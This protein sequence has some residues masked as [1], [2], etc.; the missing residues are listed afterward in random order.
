MP[1]Y[2]QCE[3]W[4]Q[5]C[6]GCQCNDLERSLRS[7]QQQSSGSGEQQCTGSYGNTNRHKYADPDTD[8]DANADRDPNRNSHAHG[9]ANRHLYVYAP[10][11]GYF[12]ADCCHADGYFNADCCY[13]NGY[14]QIDLYTV[15]D[16]N[17]CTTAFFYGYDGS[18]K[19]NA[20]G[21]P[22][23]NSPQWADVHAVADLY[24]LTYLRG[25][26]D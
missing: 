23:T 22:Y 25:N 5:W 2:S 20:I 4:R 13:A 14:K 7:G 17:Q 21:N 12:D 3:E 19:F 8:C 24:T 15:T 11:D 6:I 18:N 1:D 10:T 26:I 16:T 9:N